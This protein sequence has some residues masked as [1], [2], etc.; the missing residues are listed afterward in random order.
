VRV[1]AGGGGG[2]EVMS[3]AAVKGEKFNA[4]TAFSDSFRAAARIILL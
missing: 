3:A 1:S 2:G 4:F